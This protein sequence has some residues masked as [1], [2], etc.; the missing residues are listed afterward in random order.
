LVG[1][2]DLESRVRELPGFEDDPVPVKVESLGS[3]VAS[4]SAGANHTCA[5]LQDGAVYC[6]GYNAMG[7]L[8][9][10]SRV[11]RHVPTPVV[12]PG[13]GLSGVEAGEYELSHLTA[14][15]AGAAR[16]CAIQAGAAFCWGTS[17]GGEIGDGTEAEQRR[18]PTPVLGLD[19]GVTAI[20]AG[21]GDLVCA[22]ANGHAYCWG[23]GK[24]T[25]ALVEGL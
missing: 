15:S 24:R 3:S 19:A 22:L 11:D 25:P 14:I 21:S 17:H 16:S 7:Q 6:W 18:V 20:D 5:Q 4:L 8:G 1:G 12:T 10:N 13:T 2:G 23:M 9:D